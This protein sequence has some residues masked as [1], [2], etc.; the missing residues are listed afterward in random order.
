MTEIY[1]TDTDSGTLSVFEDANGTVRKIA[2]IRVGNAPRGSVRFTSDGRGFVSNTSANTVS[3]IDGLTHKEVRR[4]KV[5]NGPRGLFIVGKEKYLLVS[6]SGSD[7]LSIVDLSL[8]EEVRQLSTGRDPRHMAVLNEFAYVSLWGDGS[9]AKFDIKSLNSNDADGVALVSTIKLAPETFPYSL[10]IDESR[11]IALVACNAV[12]SIPVIDLKTD[13][14]CAHI[15]VRASGIRAI[16]FSNNKKYAIATL[17]RDNSAAVIDL[18]TFEVTRY[19]DA[20]PAPRG[21]ATNPDNG[22]MYVA[23][24]SRTTTARYDMPDWGSHGVTIINADS[25]ALSNR[26]LKVETTTVKSGFGPCSVSL[27]DPVSARFVRENLEE[28]V[29]YKSL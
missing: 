22:V 9:I 23:A 29:Q 16:T 25:D 20:G 3:E 7:S 17:E 12:R 14:V 4:I 1:S 8:G 5:G 11:N 27:F 13:K 26:N 15:P 19:L 6:N 2:T 28:K 24:F 10:N 21:I 18:D